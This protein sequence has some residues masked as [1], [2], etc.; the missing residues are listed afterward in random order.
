MQYYPKH[1]TTRILEMEVAKRIKPN[2]DWRIFIP[3]TNRIYLLTDIQSSHEKGKSGHGLFSM[4]PGPPCLNTIFS[5]KLD[6][7]PI[8]FQHSDTTQ[9]YLYIPR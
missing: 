1:D 3:A 4:D 6:N 5:A 7:Q 9:Y 8:I 2:Y